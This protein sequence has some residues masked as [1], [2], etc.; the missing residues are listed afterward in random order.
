ML[1]KNDRS[2]ICF[3]QVFEAKPNTEQDVF[4]NISAGIHLMSG[5]LVKEDYENLTNAAKKILTSIEP[6]GRVSDELC[7]FMIFQKNEECLLRGILSKSSQWKLLESLELATQ[8]LPHE[9]RFWWL[10]EIYK[11]KEGTSSITREANL[12]KSWEY[13]ISGAISKFS[14]KLATNWVLSC[15][16][17]LNQ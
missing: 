1:N 4:A 7:A 16:G 14:Q 17:F 8:T 2:G 13:A 5:L 10:A 6:T 12:R 11:R 9:R 15:I 3:Q